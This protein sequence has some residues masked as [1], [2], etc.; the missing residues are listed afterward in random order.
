VKQRALLALL[1]LHANEVVSRDRIID[2]LWGERPPATVAAALN[3]Y[4]SKLR[5]VL[6]GA[7]DG[8]LHTREPGYVLR[9]A[10]GQLDADRF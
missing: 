9:V 7:A 2:E 4:V 8:V 1:V 6:G 10:P 5:K 3:V